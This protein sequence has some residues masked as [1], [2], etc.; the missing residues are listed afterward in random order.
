MANPPNPPSAPTDGI[1]SG[2]P[3][4]IGTILSY[5]LGDLA[6]T[7]SLSTAIII[8]SY[9]RDVKFANVDE[10]TN[11]NGDTVAMRMAD[12]RAEV[13]VS[14]RVLSGQTVGISVGSKLVINGDSILITDIS[15]SGE[16]K[17]FAKLDLKGTAYEG[18]TGYTPSA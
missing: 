6:S 10:I 16:A 12:Y 18:I 11:S 7:P 5:G 17:G 15:I 2:N 1:V 8:D 13:S 4:E 14:G 9:K 3:L